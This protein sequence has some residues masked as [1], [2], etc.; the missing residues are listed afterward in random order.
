MN[1]P[2]EEDGYVWEPKSEE[3]AVAHL[4]FD[5]ELGTKL[6][7]INAPWAVEV[8]GQWDVLHG[9]SLWGQPWSL[10]DV[11]CSSSQGTT[12]SRSTCVASTLIT[13]IHAYS[14]D[15]IVF[16]DLTMCCRGMREWL[17]QGRRGREGALTRPDDAREDFWGMCQAT[18]EGVELLFHVSALGSV[19]Y[20]RRCSEATAVLKLKSPTPLSLTQWL[21]RWVAQVENLMVFGMRQPSSVLS[22]SGIDAGAVSPNGLPFDV[23][24][25]AS[26]YP[27][28]PDLPWTA[29]QG[30]ALLP[31]NA[32]DDV[33]DLIEQWFALH[34]ELGDA[35]QLFFGTI[36]DRDLPALNRMLNLLAF[37]ETYHRRKFDEPPLTETEHEALSKQML[38]GLPSGRER[39]VYAGRLLHA[40]AQSQ[41]QRIRWLINRAASGDP[42]L[43]E[44]ERALA[45][46]LIETRN[47]LTHFEPPNEWVAGTSYGY[48]VLAA[49]LEF[50]VEANILLDLG[51]TEAEV[52]DSLTQG[53]GW[54]DPI[55]VL[56][57]DEAPG[58]VRDNS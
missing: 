51:F 19:S 6:T 54:D 36:N 57:A 2:F 42:R 11:R 21:E 5:P 46:S 56:P 48:A 15:E 43:K 18:V 35:A 26:S 55:P 23:K 44:I 20:Y 41:R 7:L 38:D 49:A 22:L 16:T 52:Q 39:D 34:R 13:G 9:E 4:R 25:Y 37:A 17:T 40:N 53:H 8:R 45:A 29:Y 3:R 27:Q 28:V 58:R 31:A 47:H 50:V 32:V 12:N 30:R 10:F 1:E 33:G 14:Q 24:V